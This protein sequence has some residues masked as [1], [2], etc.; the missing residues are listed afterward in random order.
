MVAFLSHLSLTGP[1]PLEFQPQ[2]SRIFPTCRIRVL[3]ASRC[4]RA[5]SLKNVLVALGL[6]IIP[7]NLSSSPSPV[8]SESRIQTMSPRPPMSM[9]CSAASA[10]L[11]FL[12]RV[13]IVNLEIAVSGD[14]PGQLFLV[15]LLSH[16]ASCWATCEL[17]RFKPLVSNSLSSYCEGGSRVRKTEG[18]FGF[19]N[20]RPLGQGLP[21]LLGRERCIPAIKFEHAERTHAIFAPNCLPYP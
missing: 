21:P 2:F 12:R 6:K 19:Q 9:A 1:D 15:T 17:L 13:V 4:A 14:L 16:A 8:R 11:R 10:R 18:S 5:L 7:V 3:R 20:R